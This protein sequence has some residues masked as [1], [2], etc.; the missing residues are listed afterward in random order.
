MSKEVKVQNIIRKLYVEANGNLVEVKQIDN[1]EDYAKSVTVYSKEA[2]K[3]KAAGT[4][5]FAVSVEDFVPKKR[6]STKESVQS[7][8]ASGMSAE[9]IVAKLAQL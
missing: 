1:P 5:L 2:V 4:K 6:A 8:L 9:A 3:G 7:M